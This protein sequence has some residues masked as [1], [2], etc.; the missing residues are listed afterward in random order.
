MK[1]RSFARYLKG[2][3]YRTRQLK[4]NSIYNF[5]AGST[6]TVTRL[7]VANFDLILNTNDKIFAR[8]MV[9]TG[10]HEPTI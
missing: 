3:Y 10:A 1:L 2:L 9:L 4:L 5:L 6:Y 8:T 7:P